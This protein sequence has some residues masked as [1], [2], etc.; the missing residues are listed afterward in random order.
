MQMRAC[1]TSC[2]AHLANVGAAL[3][4]GIHCHTALVK[5]GITREEVFCM[6]D[7][8]HIAKGV[9]PLRANH[10]ARGRG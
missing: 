6:F 10:R 8:N 2:V 1:R 9:I 3:D 7:F 4:L 5:V